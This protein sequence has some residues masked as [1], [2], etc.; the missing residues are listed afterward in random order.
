MTIIIMGQG[1]NKKF[2][3]GR[4]LFT[5]LHKLILAIPAIFK[6]IFAVKDDTHDNAGIF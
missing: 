6:A 1:S 3:Q 4:A 2:F 5:I